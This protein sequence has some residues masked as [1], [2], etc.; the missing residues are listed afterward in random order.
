MQQQEEE[1]EQQQQQQDQEQEQDQEQRSTQN[2][3]FRWRKT[4]LPNA[5]ASSIEDD[6][7][8]RPL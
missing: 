1:E 2:R 6:V 5:C 3:L 8:T 7:C 4:K